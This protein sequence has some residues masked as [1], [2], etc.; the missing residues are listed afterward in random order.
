MIESGVL[1][2]TPENLKLKDYV[3][4]VLAKSF[5]MIDFPA[6]VDAVK[7]YDRFQIHYGIIGIRKILSVD[8]PPIQSVIDADLVAKLIE[9]VQQSEEPQLQVNDPNSYQ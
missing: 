2:N 1:Q 9:F 3:E 5:T 8:N 4:K 7:S 6:L